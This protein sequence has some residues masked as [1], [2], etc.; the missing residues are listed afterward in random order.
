MSCHTLTLPKRELETFPFLFNK[1]IPKIFMCILDQNGR[2]KK[3]KAKQKE[4]DQILECQTF[5][6]CL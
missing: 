2:N 1:H 5:L 3:N 4:F 6:I